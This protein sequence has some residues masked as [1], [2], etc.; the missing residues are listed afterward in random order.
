VGADRLAWAGYVVTKYDL[1]D[2]SDYATTVIYD[3]RATG[4]GSRLNEL[5]R[6]FKVPPQNLIWQPDP[7]ATVEY[8]IVLGDDWAPCQRGS[9]C[10]PAHATPTRSHKLVALRKYNRGCATFKRTHGTALFCATRLAHCW[11]LPIS[12]I[13][14]STAG[15]SGLAAAPVCR[16]HIRRFD[17]RSRL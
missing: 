16:C 2:R 14:L 5:G 11:S 17:Q 4:K 9:G 7:N 3:Y 12:L 8:R 6:L 1:A 13:V 10:L 15:C